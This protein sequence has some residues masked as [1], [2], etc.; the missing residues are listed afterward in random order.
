MTDPAAR[1]AAINTA[2]ALRAGAMPWVRIMS[3]LVIIT[4][5]LMTIAM[6]V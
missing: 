1:S 2:N 6:Y 3:V 4:A 5:I